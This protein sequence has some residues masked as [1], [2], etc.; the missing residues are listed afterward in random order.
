MASS[1]SE[2]DGLP[3]RKLLGIGTASGLAAWSILAAGDAPPAVVVGTTVPGAIDVRSLG[4]KGDG[5][6]DDTKAIQRALDLGTRI[7]IPPGNYRITAGLKVR[8]NGTVVQG[9]SAATTK[10]LGVLLARR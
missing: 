8:T 2:P 6:T 10:S 5:T 4:A 3:R 1:E 9:A 7:F